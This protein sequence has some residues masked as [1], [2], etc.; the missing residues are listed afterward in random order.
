VRR[1]N[2]QFLSKSLYSLRK[3]ATSRDRVHQP[4]TLNDGREPR[5]DPFHGVKSLIASM[6]SVPIFLAEH[7]ISRSLLYRLIKEGRG[8]R[9]TKINGRTLISAEAAA[10]WRTKMEKETEQV[11]PR[12]KLGDVPRR[13]HSKPAVAALGVV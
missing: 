9:I 2:C 1:R 10:D 5:W 7:G 6:L 12:S 8:P 4:D 13:M 3:G 11:Q